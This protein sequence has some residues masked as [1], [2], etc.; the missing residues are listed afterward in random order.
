LKSVPEDPPTTPA[1]DWKITG[2]TVPKIDGRDFVTG[3]HP[4]TPDIQVAGMLHGKILRPAAF[5]ATLT[6]LD[7]GPADAMAGV[8]VIRDGD[9][10]GVT[11]PTEHLA[12]AAVEALR[13]TPQISD[14]EL[15]EQLKGKAPE[16]AGQSA[17]EK[18]E[19]EKDNLSTSPRTLRQTYTIAYIAHAPL[20][21]RAAVA[22]WKDD[23]LTVW[24]GTQRPFGVRSELAQVFRIP[25]ERIRVIVPDT[26]SG[27]GGKHT[28]EAA[29]EAARL[30]KSAGKPVKLV[31]T[32][33]EEF[34][35]AYFRP[36]GVIDVTGNVNSDGKI[37]GWEFHNYN[38]GGAGLRALYDI[39]NQKSEFHQ[40]RSPLRQGSYRALASTA[41]HF[42]RESISTTWR[43][44]SKWIRSNSV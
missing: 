2:T 32:R 3:R 11:A 27:Y 42:A 17:S 5:G 20:E 36:A 24:T 21:P 28:G 31:W 34:T 12:A 18:P 15:F 1:S 16:A 40:A 7:T 26:G 22:E 6:S 33:E 9:F 10:A 23:K 8:R 38:S 37:T 44:Q 4:Y 41:N 13:A 25:E 19:P 43:V 30:A 35:W 29:V 39:P 14:G